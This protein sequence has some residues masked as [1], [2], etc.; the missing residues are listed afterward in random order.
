MEQAQIKRAAGVSSCWGDYIHFLIY[1]N[2][3][4]HNSIDVFPP[5]AIIGKIVKENTTVKKNLYL[6][7]A[8]LGFILPYYF[9]FKFYSANEMTTS[10]A[11]S[12]LVS[13][14][15]GALLAADLTISVFAAWTFIY[16]EAKRLKMK[17]W[18]AYPIATMMVGLSFAL[19]LFLYF[20]ERQTTEA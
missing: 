2:I 10:A 15:W 5:H 8:V 18:W 13:T 4:L 11:L 6:I 16:N 20:R 3:F 9:I 17:Y 1:V 7:L 14:D 19:P 12:Q